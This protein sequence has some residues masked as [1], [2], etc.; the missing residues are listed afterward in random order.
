M[1]GVSCVFTVRDCSELKYGTEKSTTCSR[2]SVIV[3]AAATMSNWSPAT[4]GEDRV[5]VRLD[6]HDLEPESAGD[7]LMMSMSK[8]VSTPASTD[9]NGG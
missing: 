9:S 5:E 1:S 6:P 2:S 4:R 8:P 3:E 7:L